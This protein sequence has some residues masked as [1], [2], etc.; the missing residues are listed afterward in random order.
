M[1]LLHIA[2]LTH[3]GKLFEF[4]NIKGDQ[5]ETALGDESKR[6]WVINQAR[7]KK[8][9][10]T[11]SWDIH[12]ES[13]FTGK[14]YRLHISVVNS[15]LADQAIKALSPHASVTGDY[16]PGYEFLSLSSEIG[17]ML[18]NNVER[19]CKKEKI[20]FGINIS[21]DFNKN[22]TTATIEFRL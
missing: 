22:Q 6:K 4:E 10:L 3:F 1:E 17:A 13:S 20:G 2:E 15:G 14:S 7:E 21:P 5:V 9:N 19:L 11:I 8:Q 12:P 18:I 16:S